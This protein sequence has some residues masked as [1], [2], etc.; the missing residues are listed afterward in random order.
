VG[1]DVRHAEGRRALEALARRTGVE[2]HVRIAG[3]RPHDEVPRWLA[4]AD[5]FCLGTRSEG[6]CNA[7]TE[8]LACGLPVVTTAVGGNPEVVQDGED[9]FLVPFWDRAAFVAA[10]LR[11]LD[12]RWDRS[13]IAARAGTRGW[14]RTAEDVME[15]LR[16]T[17]MV[18]PALVASE[19]ARTS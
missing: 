11:A 9:G 12:R 1:G 19:G 3:A 15:T 13:A 2:A 17:L 8:S 16:A 10:V 7:L 4:A 14:E 18:K 6:W 5:L